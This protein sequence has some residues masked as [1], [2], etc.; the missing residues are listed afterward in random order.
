MNYFDQRIENAPHEWKIHLVDIMDT[1]DSV[2]LFFESEEKAK[3][4]SPELALGLTKLVVERRDAEQQRL[5]KNELQINNDQA[6][7]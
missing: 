7:A 2:S 3:L 6:N 5:E 1:F 4:Y